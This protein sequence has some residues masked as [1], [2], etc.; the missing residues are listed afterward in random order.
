[1]RKWEKEMKLKDFVEFMKGGAG[2]ARPWVVLP[3]GKALAEIFQGY[4]NLE[5]EVIVRYESDYDQ[6]KGYLFYWSVEGIP[7][8]EVE[9]FCPEAREIIPDN[10]RIHV[11]RLHGSEKVNGFCFYFRY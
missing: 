6:G 4:P 5:K 3:I 8:Q 7:F 1:M 11:A 9:Q 10:C 2:W